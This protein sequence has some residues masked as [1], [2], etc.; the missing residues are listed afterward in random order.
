V[1]GD[2]CHMLNLMCTL[3]K[4]KVREA[5]FIRYN[6]VV[7]LMIHGPRA[8]LLLVFCG[9][10]DY[11]YVSQNTCYTFVLIWSISSQLISFFISIEHVKGLNFMYFSR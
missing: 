10:W 9:A 3:F 4:G 8:V 11:P 7:H 2:C 1:K 6:G 5:K